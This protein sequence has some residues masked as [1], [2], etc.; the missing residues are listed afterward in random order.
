MIELSVNDVISNA[1]R[2]DAAGD[3]RSRLSAEAREALTEM[4][5]EWPM[6]EPEPIAGYVVRGLKLR[7]DRKR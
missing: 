4:L 2:R 6:P 7:V 1:L 3:P 5:K